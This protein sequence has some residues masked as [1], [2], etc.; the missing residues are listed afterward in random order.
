MKT[1]TAARVA[2]FAHGAFALLMLLLGVALVAPVAMAGWYALTG[3][4]HTLR[5]WVILGGVAML[6]FGCLDWSV[7]SI[8]AD[9]RSLMAWNPSRSHRKA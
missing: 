9:A 8:A 4:E 6:G 1:T 2:V 7:P 5:E 3:A